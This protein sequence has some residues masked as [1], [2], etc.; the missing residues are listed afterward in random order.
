VPETCPEGFGILL[1][2]VLFPVFLLVDLGNFDQLVAVQEHF[3]L[4]LEPI[5]IEIILPNPLHKRSHLS[6]SLPLGRQEDAMSEP[7]WP[8]TSEFVDFFR[9]F[10]AEQDFRR[11]PVAP[12]LLDACMKFEITGTITGDDTGKGRVDFSIEDDVG[13]LV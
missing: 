4:V 10:L 6:P 8:S 5:L 11:E 1:W 7:A 2:P 9:R 12:Q 3:V 13:E